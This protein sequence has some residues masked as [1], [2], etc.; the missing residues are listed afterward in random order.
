MLLQEGHGNGLHLQQS[1][2]L[3]VVHIHDLQDIPLTIRALQA[4]VLVDVA[5]QVSY[6]I[7]GLAIKLQ[8]QIGGLLQAEGGP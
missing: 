3:A 4:E 1:A 7:H 2:V 6:L 8:H 5:G